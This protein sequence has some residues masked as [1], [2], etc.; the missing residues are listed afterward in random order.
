MALYLIVVQA[1]FVMNNVFE[2]MIWFFLPAALVITNDIF[3]Y[4]CGIAFGR[5]Q[6]IKL[7]PKKT[8]EGFV[9]AWITTVLFGTI[10]VNLM[11]RSKYFICPVNVSATTPSFSLF[12]RPSQ[13][14][15]TSNND[16]D[17]NREIIQ[18]LGAT[19]FTGLECDPNPVFIA[20]T[21][22]MPELFFLPPKLANLSFTFAPI[23]IHTF[24]LA[25]FASLIAPFG[26]FFA[27]GLKRSFKL[28]DFGD[29]IPGHGGMTD[30]MDCQFIMGFF[31]YMYYHTFISL[32]KVTMGSI[33]ETAIT[34]LSP[35]EQVELVKSMARYLGNQG[36][37]SQKVSSQCP[38]LLAYLLQRAY[39]SK[40]LI[41]FGS[42]WIVLSARSAIKRPQ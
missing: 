2:G 14:E 10:L 1:H 32:H 22:H 20:R 11:S 9:G 36:V 28:K 33:L 3:A 34:S 13:T 7:S 16:R 18:D 25:S 15:I 40:V 5:T 21:Y 12:A 39:L 6:L 35:E 27:S 37:V 42:F 8:V 29:S 4:I 26:G 41:D 17:S 19:V 30:R 31:A 38:S 23:Q 24:V